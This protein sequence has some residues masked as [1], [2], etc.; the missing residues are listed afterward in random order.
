MPP[1]RTLAIGNF[2]SSIHFF[3]IVY[4]ITPY[5]ATFLPAEQTGLVVSAGAVATLIAFPT[6]PK[7][8][9]RYGAKR[10]VIGVAFVLGIAL[11]VLASQPS[12]WVAALALAF[13]CATTPFVQY[14]LDLLLEATNASEQETGRVRTAFITA[15]NVALILSPLIIGFLLGEGDAYWRVFLVGGIS[16]APFIALFLIE[17]LP[18]SSAREHQKLMDTC[19]CMI[20]DLDLRAAAFGNLVLQLFYH[21]APLY[22]PLYLHEVLG[23]PWSELGWIFMVMLLPFVLLEYPAGYIAD[24]WLGDK[25]LLIT[26]FIIIGVSFGALAFVTSTT[27]LAL[28]LTALIGTRVGAALV[29]A[30]VEGHFFRRVSADDANTVTLYRMSRPVSALIAPLVASIILFMT[31]SYMVFF[32]STSIVIVVLGVLSAREV[33][34]VR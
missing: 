22:I 30:M 4:V 6:M 9:S 18:E 26:G 11:F 15:A 24:R 25:E 19:R 13:I 2:F 20:A 7:L 3:L 8:A 32:L 17:E 28:L 33:R 5:L 21:L 10:S 23:M 31:G 16:L 12:F 34:D 14:F 1:R 29:E 27:P